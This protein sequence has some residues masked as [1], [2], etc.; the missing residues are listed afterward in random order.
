MRWLITLL[1]V[2]FVLCSNTSWAETITL[3][4]TGWTQDE[5]NH[6]G[7]MSQ[8]LARE[9]GIDVPY[10]DVEGNKVTF[11]KEVGDAITTQKVK[12]RWAV[13]VVMNKTR[14]DAERD[15][16]NVIRESTKNKLLNG[17]PLTNEEILFIFPSLF[18]TD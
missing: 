3:D 2:L 11:T 12:D 6:I 8:R 5:K 13:Q 17:D 10:P 1:I 18:S 14:D 16:E 15:R 7:A 4:L 9:A